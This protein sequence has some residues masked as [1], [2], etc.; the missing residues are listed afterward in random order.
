MSFKDLY[1]SA[2]S[3]ISG[4]RNLIDA[5]YEKAEEKPVFNFKYATLCA[6]S[7]ILVVSLGIFPVINKESK[8]PNVQI[9]KKSPESITK[10]EKEIETDT[11]YTPDEK[12]IKNKN[13]NVGDS[14]QKEEKSEDINVIS[15][16][17]DISIP[18]S[19]KDQIAHDNMT[20]NTEIISNSGGAFAVAASDV[21]NENL[22]N[23][24]MTLQ[25]YYEYLGIENLNFNSSLPYGMSFDMPEY[26]SVLLNSQTNAIEDDLIQFVAVDSENPQKILTL[27]TTTKKQ[28]DFRYNVITDINGINVQKQS[29]GNTISVYFE[30]SRAGITV[31]SYG[32]SEEDMDMF[33]KGFLK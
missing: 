29:N 27:S 18:S 20:R 17:T 26:V 24:Q 32:V 16:E 3:N 22:V 8:K 4:D 9:A 19:E 33:L 5:I 6:A 14:Y 23:E 13:T 30:Y 7:I 15:Q 2:Y 28:N 10:V 11:I 25:K 31:H 21:P 1:K 12:K